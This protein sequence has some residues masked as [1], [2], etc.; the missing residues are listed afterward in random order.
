MLRNKTD[1]MAWFRS[2]SERL[3]EEVCLSLAY[4]ILITQKG[5]VLTSPRAPRMRFGFFLYGGFASVYHPDFSSCFGSTPPHAPLS[6]LWKHCSPRAFACQCG[7]EGAHFL[8]SLVLCKTIWGEKLLEGTS[9]PGALRHGV[10]TASDPVGCGSPR[11]I[12]SL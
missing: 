10:L 8:T 4:T 3:L 12:S 5:W 11:P 6:G 9:Y 7:Q 2:K 1:C